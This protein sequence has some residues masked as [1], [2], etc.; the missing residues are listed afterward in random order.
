[1]PKTPIEA[2]PFKA[3]GPYNLGIRVGT[4]LYV[5]GQIPLDPATMGSVPNVGLMA[6]A[7]RDAVSQWEPRAELEQVE[8]VPDLDDPSRVD[9]QVWYRVRTTNDAATSSTRST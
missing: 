6:Q 4:A 3:V 9:I 2:P 8:V 7:V 5:S 1:M